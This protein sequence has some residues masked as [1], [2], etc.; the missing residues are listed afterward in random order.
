[1]SA[2]MQSNWRQKSAAFRAAAQAGRDY[3][4]PTWGSGG[5]V[6]SGSFNGTSHRP[7]AG[8]ALAAVRQRTSPEK[9][10]KVPSPHM[11]QSGAFRRKSAPE[12]ALDSIDE[13]NSTVGS[14]R[15]SRKG[16]SSSTGGIRQNNSSPL[17]QWGSGAP[18]R[19]GRE[20]MTSPPV[21]TTPHNTSWGGCNRVGAQ[22]KEGF[23]STRCSFG[24]PL[25][26][27]WLYENRST[28]IA[29]QKIKSTVP[30]P[31]PRGVSAAPVLLGRG[32][33]NEPRHVHFA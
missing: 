27:S 33:G 23:E 18:S 3:P 29:P 2:P 13:R 4:M 7:A 17:P 31:V 20:C 5:S 15:Q 26:R 11:A 25:D 19:Y 14:D 9:N 28:N 32:P 1:M 16:R 24:N 30:H 6:S 22:E 12:P 10:L 8:S 21:L